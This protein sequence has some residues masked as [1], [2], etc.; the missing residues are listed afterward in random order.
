[1][2]GG[3]LTPGD[4]ADDARWLSDA[5]LDTIPVTHGLAGYLRGAKVFARE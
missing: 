1:V 3:V 4:D 2:V 5:E